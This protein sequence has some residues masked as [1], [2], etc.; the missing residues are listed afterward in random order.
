M[1]AADFSPGRPEFCWPAARRWMM[2]G[3]GSQA[4][5][6]VSA[7]PA[8]LEKCD[9]SVRSSNNSRVQTMKVVL[10]AGGMGTRLAE[11]TDLK[12]KPMVNIGGRPL[13]WHI[14]KHY[15]TFG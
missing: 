4:I 15:A 5:H 3:N 10:L 2:A 8:Q 13:L 6:G 12:P 9:E 11:E 14:M 1:P 7:S